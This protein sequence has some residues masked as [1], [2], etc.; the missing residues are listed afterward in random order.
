MLP[1]EMISQA[2]PSLQAWT[3]AL[4][5]AEIPV[6]ASTVL[7]VAEL[8]AIE[9]AKGTV[10]AHMLSDSL[11][12]DPLMT[13]K[14]LKH[15]SSYCTRL[16]VEPPE[17]LTG[18]IVMQG[19][20]PFFRAFSSMQDAD[21]HLSAHPEAHKGLYRSIR[22]SRRAA[23]FATNFAM[24]RQDQDVM[25]IREAALLHD[26]AEMLLYCVAPALAEDIERRLANDP[27]LNASQAQ[28]DVLGSDLGDL[29]Q[30]LMHAWQLPDLLIRCTDDRHAE[31]PQ[32]RTVMLAVR[33]A[34]HTQ[35]G[36]EDAHAQ[37]GLPDDI[38]AVAELLTISQSSAERKLREMD[39]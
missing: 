15:V 27:A 24:Q 37:A 9:D 10:D 33:I 21:Q 32:V 13:L 2:L 5:D 16:N 30:A 35:Y 11:D 28:I 7:R 18:A 8:A 25:V 38:S 23:N 6:M 14:V 34:R 4:V 31:H 22:R 3:D 39:G 29:S 1:Q 20:G 26:F 19:I 12:H 17:T 36:W